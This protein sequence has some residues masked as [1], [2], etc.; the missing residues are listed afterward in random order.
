MSTLAS[1][2]D[3]ANTGSWVLVGLLAIAVP[4]NVFSGDLAWTVF[5]V[6]MVTIL[7]LP[8]VAFRD[9]AAMLP[10]E[11]VGL[12]VLPAVTR[13]FWPF[14]PAWVGEYATYLAVAALALAV[15]TELALF[16]SAE[17]SPWFAAVTVLLTTMAAIGVW[18]VLQFYSD[19][20]LRTD[21]LGSLDTLMWEFVQ[22]TVAGVIAALFFEVY[23]RTRAP[24]DASGS[25]VTDEGGDGA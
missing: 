1:L 8:P 21:L 2:V 17:M 20:Y 14:G 10:P 11:V 23:F 5:M 6:G 24:M 22:A 9:P 15:V 25:A 12:A 3:D 19:A 4:E 18:A 7:L 16:T 13:A